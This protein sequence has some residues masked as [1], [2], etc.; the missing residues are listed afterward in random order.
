[1]TREAALLGVPTAS[2]FAG[3]VPAVDRWLEQ[4]GMLVRPE[5]A[6]D[7]PEPRPPSISGDAELAAAAEPILE[8]FVAATEAAGDG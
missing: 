1:M 3:E 2:V 8:L 4:R 6:A 7:L 5:T